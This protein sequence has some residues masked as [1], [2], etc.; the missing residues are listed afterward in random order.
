MNTPKLAPF[1]KKSLGGSTMSRNKSVTSDGKPKSKHVYWTKCLFCGVDASS[2]RVISEAHIIEAVRNYSYEGFGVTAGYLDDLDPTSGRNYIPLCGTLGQPN[3]CHHAFDTFKIALLYNPLVR[4]YYLYT[5]S[6][7]P[8]QILHGTVINDI[9][10]KFKPYRRL[11][12]ARA[13]ATGYECLDE[14]MLNLPNLTVTE[15]QS[16]QSTSQD[17]PS[18]VYSNNDKKRS[19]EAITITSDD[20]EPVKR[21]NR[22]IRF[23]KGASTSSK[24]AVSNGS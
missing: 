24:A 5:P 22:T 11:L 20:C 4:C 1:F 9:P 18:I 21:Q 16:V 17:A 13:Y 19:H 23:S 15:R 14:T 6:N 3:T 2:D 8:N 12:A 10:E 7:Y